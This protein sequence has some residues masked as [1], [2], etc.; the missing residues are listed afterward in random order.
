VA[1]STFK[2]LKQTDK[3]SDEYQ[4]YRNEWDRREKDLDPGLA[5]VHLDLEVSAICDLRCGA[6]LADPKGFCNIHTHEHI[7]TQGF[8]DKTYKP[9]LMDPK[10]YYQLMLDAYDL[11]VQSI[12]LN[13]RGEPTLHPEIISFIAEADG[14]FLDI[15]MNTNGNGGAR[16]DPNIFTRIVEAGITNLMFS[17]DA[18]SG[19][20]YK[21]QRV[22]GDWQLL[23]NS[24]K[25][26]IEAR[27][28]SDSNSDCRIRASVV[29]TSLNKD[30]VDSGRMQEFWVDQMGVDWLS[31][32]ECY[33][34]A[35]INHPWAASEWIPMYEDEFA[36]ADPFRRM[37][38]T[39]DGKHTFPCCQSFSGEVDGGNVLALDDLDILTAW[40]SKEFNHLRKL[41]IS[42]KWSE[43]MM[44]QT[45]PLTHKPFP[46]KK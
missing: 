33:Y 11:G 21:K 17:V 6:T 10:L 31:I 40:H 25:T 42:R 36:C 27:K 18:C 30:D 5:P 39:W 43:S 29:R 16:K 2:V 44:C 26:A 1:D 32:S 19:K 28:K 22:G 24:V 45:C 14:L 7:R 46:L 35:G 15:M 3:R 41:H 13:F 38:I 4:D 34:P 8:K 20:S 23:L 9:G 37:I 12:K